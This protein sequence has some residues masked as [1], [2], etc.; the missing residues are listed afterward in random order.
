MNICPSNQHLE[1]YQNVNKKVFKSQIYEKSFQVNDYYEVLGE[2][3]SGSYGKVFL[4][5]D[6]S[7]GQKMAMK[8]YSNLFRDLV[9]TS[10]I[11]K[12]IALMRYISQ[13]KTASDHFR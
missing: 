3:G 4:V 12:E 5:K 6:K 9:D 8:E 10:R 13:L 11:Y 2:I 7:S 1:D